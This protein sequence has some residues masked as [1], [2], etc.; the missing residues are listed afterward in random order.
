MQLHRIKPT[1]RWPGGKVLAD[2]PVPKAEVAIAALKE[3]VKNGTCGIGECWAE[4]SSP[5]QIALRALKYIGAE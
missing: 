2:R 5:Q 1:A 4:G 3:I